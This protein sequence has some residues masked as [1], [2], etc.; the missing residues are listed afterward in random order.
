VQKIVFSWGFALDPLGELTALPQIP[1]VVGRGR[2]APSPL[3]RGVGS[4]VSTPVGPGAKLRPKTILAAHFQACRRHLLE[5]VFVTRTVLVWQNDV[6]Y[7]P[8]SI[9]NIARLIFPTNNRRYAVDIVLFLEPPVTRSAT[10]PASATDDGPG[11]RR[12][13]L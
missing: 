2:I 9:A 3:V 1:Y 13:R 5:A 7:C 10:N 6:F 8:H 12:S 11:R 4:A